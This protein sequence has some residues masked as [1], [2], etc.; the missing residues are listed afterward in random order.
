MEDYRDG[1]PVF[2]HDFQH[3]GRIENVEILCCHVLL[4]RVDDGQ[5]VQKEQAASTLLQ[6]MYYCLGIG[7]KEI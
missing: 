3:S 2:R 6:Q 5:N 7:A 1:Y 4:P